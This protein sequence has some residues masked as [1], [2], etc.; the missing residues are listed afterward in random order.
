M[1]GEKSL[2]PLS[3]DE[4]MGLLEVKWLQGGWVGCG[5]GLPPPKWRMVMMGLVNGIDLKWIG[6]R[7]SQPEIVCLVGVFLLSPWR[8]LEW[9]VKQVVKL[10]LVQGDCY[11]FITHY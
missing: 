11:C 3:W 4:E 1:E 2:I 7:Q 6:W 8:G 10:L 9:A 5:C